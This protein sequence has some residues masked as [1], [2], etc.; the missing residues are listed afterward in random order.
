MASFDEAIVSVSGRLTHEWDFT[1]YKNSGEIANRVRKELGSVLKQINIDK[2]GDIDIDSV[3]EGNFIITP[4]AVLSGGWLTDTKSLL[5]QQAVEEFAGIIELLAK[6]NG[7]FTVEFF[8][9]RLF[10]RFR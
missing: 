8:N 10:F 9:V 2:D 5:A 4:G 7:S 3:N 6:S 1:F